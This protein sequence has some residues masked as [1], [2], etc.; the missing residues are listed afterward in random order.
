[1]RYKRRVRAATMA[2]IGLLTPRRKG[3]VMRGGVFAGG[4]VFVEG[5]DI[6]APDHADRPPA[7]SGTSSAA[8]P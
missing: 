3:R 1:M 2:C 5:S 4:E 7:R 8:K 6:A